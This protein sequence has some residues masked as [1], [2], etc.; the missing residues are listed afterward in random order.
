MHVEL[1]IAKNIETIA[2][3]RASE[4]KLNTEQQKSTEQVLNNDQNL[5]QI[6][7][8]FNAVIIPEK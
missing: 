7:D 1:T 2:T 6:L 3:K 8:K 5:K 4:K